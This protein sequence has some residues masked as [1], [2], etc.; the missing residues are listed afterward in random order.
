[1]S[2][3]TRRNIAPYLGLILVLAAI[4]VIS[5]MMTS[6]VHNMNYSTFMKNLKNN[7]VETVELSPN[8]KG[9]IY[10]ITGKMKGYGNKESYYTNC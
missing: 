4:Y 3:K 8:T 7:K 9:S 1:M 5:T 10:E 2:K 6:K